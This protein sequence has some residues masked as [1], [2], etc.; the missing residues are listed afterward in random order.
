MKKKQMKVLDYMGMDLCLRN[1]YYK[2]KFLNVNMK[3]QI[4]VL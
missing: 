2:S 3:K 4:K 1:G